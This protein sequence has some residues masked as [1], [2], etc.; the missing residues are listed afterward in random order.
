MPRGNAVACVHLAHVSSP[1]S[2]WCCDAR[3]VRRWLSLDAAVK[4]RRAVGGTAP[5]NIERRLKHLGV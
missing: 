5:G 1:P 3:D 2:S 4:R